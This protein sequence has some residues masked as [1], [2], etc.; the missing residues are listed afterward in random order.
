MGIADEDIAKV[1]E[2]TDIVAVISQYTQL[3]RAG[4]QWSGLCP[5]HTEKTPSFYANQELGVYHCWGCQ[6]QG[7]VI[8]F[9]RE[10]EHLDFV[11]AVELLA[12][13]AGIA[14]RYTERDEGESRRRRARLVEAVGRAVDWYHD[15]LLSSPDAAA[16]RRYLRERGLT[17]DDVR[18]FRLGF[19]PDAWDAMVRGVK[20]PTPDL[21][22]TDLAREGRRG[23][24]DRFRNRVLFPVFDANGDAVGFGARA[25]P[26]SADRA[27]YINTAETTLY[28]KSHLL[29]ALNW[30]KARIVSDDR[31][32]VC[33]GYTDVIGFARA[34]LPAAVATCGTALT[35][36]HVRLLRRYARR[37]VL[38]FDA[39]A[40]GQAAADRFY[41]W[42]Q[43]HELEVSV[44]SLPAGVDPAELAA[45]DP[46]AL[47]AA[48]DGAK[49]FLAFRVDRVL[50]AGDLS[51]AEGR[52]R[53]A[54]AALDMIAE[55]P[56]ELVRDQYV[57]EVA[58]RCRI[59]AD[60][61]R[62]SLAGRRS[63][64][65]R[66]VPTPSVA[67]RPSS[68]A[69]GPEV[70]A[71]RHVVHSW[72]AVGSWIHGGLFADPLH[73]A[74]YRDLVGHATVAEAIEA[75]HPAVAELLARLAVQDPDSDPFDVVVRLVTEA[76][77]RALA[78]A[79]AHL[80]AHPDDMEALRTQQW[81]KA[82]LVQLDDP[83]RRTTAAEQLVAWLGPRGE[84]G[85]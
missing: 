46:E 19:A 75:A 18:S 9:V 83:E 76:A 29:Y 10:I 82:S 63:G 48:V 37:I 80:V 42:E 56:S 72:D 79:R 70:E 8:T 12:G 65:P 3:K 47:R 55:H 49:P 57:M 41:R 53:T 34:G 66:E 59:D 68:G 67:P 62:R 4:R 71:L 13:K 74:A 84:E 28:R 2:A 77:R 35:E 64:G 1:R 38:A 25:M 21:M 17:G 73:A 51:S 7:D 36:E 44:A 43:D 30:S 61:L 32:V 6:A 14:L 26:G 85:A 40:A 23:P 24:I 20:V 15:R 54:A 16:A 78:E 11:A 58:D 81:L 33:E 52:A 45:E 50:A 69:G 60:Q 5:F 39:D 27:K 22:E 31:A